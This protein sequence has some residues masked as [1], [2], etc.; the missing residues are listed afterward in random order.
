MDLYLIFLNS[1]QSHSSPTVL[2][3]L[4]VL[5]TLLSFFL[6][7]DSISVIVEAAAAAAAAGTFAQLSELSEVIIESGL[8]GFI[9]LLV[10][11]N[12]FIK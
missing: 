3:A 2:S 9:Y 7:A 5:S 1:T 11:L 10:H 8:L 4:S 12:I 6:D